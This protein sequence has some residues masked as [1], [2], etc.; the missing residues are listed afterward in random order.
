[1]AQ[2]EE[3]VV[4]IGTENTPPPGK[5]PAKSASKLPPSPSGAVNVNIEQFERYIQELEPAQWARLNFYIY[6]LV[7]AIIKPKP[8]NIDKP[9]GPIDR[10]Y[11]LARHGS[12]KY[13]LKLNDAGGTGTIIKT[14]VQLDDPERPNK[15]LSGSLLQFLNVKDP[16][17]R[18]IVEVLQAEGKLSRDGLVVTPAIPESEN[19][20]LAQALRDVALKAMENKGGQQAQGTEAQ[21]YQRSLGII[22]DAS[23]QSLQ[24]VME[25][26]KTEGK[27][28]DL[29]AIMPLL[30][31]LINQKNTPA[32]AP[33]TT[34]TTILT[35]MLAAA[36]RRAE[37]AEKTA[38]E[39][40][41]EAAVERARQHE[42]SLK[43]MESRA[44]GTNPVEMLKQMKEL[45]ALAGGNEP[46]NRNW[47]EKLVDEGMQYVPQLLEVAGKFVGRPAYQPGAAQPQPQT[48]QPQPN[49]SAVSEDTAR[50]QPQ[51]ELIEMPQAAISSDPEICFLY[52]I[53][54]AKGGDLVNFFKSDPTSGPLVAD[55]VRTMGGAATYER[56]A[57]MGVDRILATI[58]LIPQ[59]EADFAAAGSADML[60]TFIEDFVGDEDDEDEEPV[61]PEAGKPAKQKK[62]KQGA[63]IA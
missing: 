53:F 7:P 38:S 48:R 12:G 32:P 23:T 20:S 16:E 26:T 29:V 13:H 11:I 49:T 50:Q 41:K 44:N 3:Q 47:K 1:M 51:G 28:G 58:K 8:S 52:P 6:Q 59:M 40:R 14:I 42:I 63:P 15:F 61:I 22:G 27:G 35:Q 19:A 17:N 24:M 10:E 57:Q 33:D 34:V 43:A 2:V 55:L 5:K 21:A 46:D 30:L 60:R 31:A 39:E 9:S 54:L 56:I 25:R 37:A 62:S 36:E 4:D 18:Q 45:Q